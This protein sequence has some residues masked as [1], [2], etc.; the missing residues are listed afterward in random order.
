MKTYLNLVTV[1]L[2]VIWRC[3]RDE[4]EARVCVMKKPLCQMY[5]LGKDKKKPL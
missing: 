2:W 5:I 1:M 4:N 3:L